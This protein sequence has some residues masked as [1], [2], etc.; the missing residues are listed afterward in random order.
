MAAKIRG[1]YANTSVYDALGN[2]HCSS[3]FFLFEGADPLIEFLRS[4][5]RTAVSTIFFKAFW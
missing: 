1:N 4:E 5:G 2:F 3:S